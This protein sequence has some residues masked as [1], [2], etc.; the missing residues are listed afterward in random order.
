MLV[1]NSK[2][3]RYFNNIRFR[4]AAKIIIKNIQTRKIEMNPVT[5]C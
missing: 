5:L 1:L 3:Q 4:K 2:N